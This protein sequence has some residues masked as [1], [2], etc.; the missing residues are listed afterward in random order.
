MADKFKYSIP[1][2]L[3]ASAVVIFTGLPDS[4]GVYAKSIVPINNT[5]GQHAK[6]IFDNLIIS[7]HIPLTG[8]LTNGDYNQDTLDA[9]HGVSFNNTLYIGNDFWTC[10][11][12][13]F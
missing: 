8:H 10:F 3:I 12:N 4:A 2:M 11:Q 9:L 6:H 1:F 5:M 7:Q 13:L